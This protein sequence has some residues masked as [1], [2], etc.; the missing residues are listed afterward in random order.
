MGESFL[1]GR[2]ILDW[3]V[4]E[5]ELP[6]VDARRQFSST[7]L[8]YLAQRASFRSP[9][10]QE[11]LIETVGARRAF[12]ILTR[13]GGRRLYVPRG[14]YDS[15][16]PTSQTRFFSPDELRLL[17]E[18]W[19]GEY[20]EVPVGRSF[21]ANFLYWVADFNIPA[22]AGSLCMCENGARRA[23]STRPPKY[24]SAVALDCEAQRTDA[25]LSARERRRRVFKLLDLPAEQTA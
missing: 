13:F 11:W 2:S 4:D 17:Q 21:R 16:H 1:P 8:H 14:S 23:V 24:L 22:I 18:H 7:G 3:R 15:L 6:P 25:R 20:L 5:R 9:K 12:E 10:F 19:R